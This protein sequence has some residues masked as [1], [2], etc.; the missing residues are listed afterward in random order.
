MTDSNIILKGEMRGSEGKKFVLLSKVNG[1]KREIDASEN[2][3][4]T[5]TTEPIKS[6]KYFYFAAD[7]LA[8]LLA[9]LN[10]KLVLDQN[11]KEFKLTD[12]KSTNITLETSN[13]DEL[14]AKLN[15]CYDN[16]FV[17]GDYFFHK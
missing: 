2:V 5:F 11:G 14:L 9:V 17:E 6:K 15:E 3:L 16:F 4:S 8:Y 7:R 10:K 1:E 13:F 12:G